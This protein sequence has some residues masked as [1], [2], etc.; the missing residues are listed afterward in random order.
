MVYVQL[1]CQLGGGEG[2]PPAMSCAPTFHD[3]LLEV[4]L[5]EAHELL[6]A[7]MVGMVA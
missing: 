7:L 6:H 1:L 4:F 3:G 5:D 2:T